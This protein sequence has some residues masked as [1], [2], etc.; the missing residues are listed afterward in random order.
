MS[1]GWQTSSTPRGPR[2]SSCNSPTTGTATATSARPR[3]RAPSSGS[4]TGSSAARSPSVAPWRREARKAK[5]RRNGLT[6]LAAVPACRGGRA[7]PGRRGRRPLYEAV[8]PWARARRG[9]RAAAC[10]RGASR[11]SAT[12]GGPRLVSRPHERVA[13]IGRRDERLLDRPRAHP[14]EQVH[15]APRLVVRPRRARAAEGLL[16]NDGARRLIVDVEVAGRVGQRLRHPGDRRAIP[17]E[18]RAGERVGRAPVA[19]R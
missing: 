2:E 13:K 1:S 7:R 19:E 12:P 14:A 11:G 5:A 17:R 8:D 10:R 3:R 18:D 16:A 9:T 6:A 4:L 15:E